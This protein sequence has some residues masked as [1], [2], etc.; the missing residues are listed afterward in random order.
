MKACG[1]VIRLAVIAFAATCATSVGSCFAK[2]AHQTQQKPATEQK[3]QPSAE[4]KAPTA[5]TPPD[6]AEEQSTAA[7]DNEADPTITAL[8]SLKWKYAPQVG[9]IG[10]E[11]TIALSSDVAF[12]GA[13]DT[14]R[15]LEI[16]GN[17]PCKQLNCYAL[18]AQSFGWFAIFSFDQSGYVKDDETIDP[19]VLLK[20]LK[21]NNVSSLDEKRQRGL[22]LLYLDGWYIP[23]HY[24][25]ISKRLEWGTKA[26][27]E[28][29][30]I[31]VNY[32]IRLLGRD[33]V[34][35]A[36]LV[37]N[38]SSLDVDLK[39]FKQALQNFTFNA[40]KTY[41]EFREGDKV[42]EYGLT[43]LIVGGA[44]AAAAK[45]GVGKGLFAAGAG[46]IKLLAVGALALL[47]GVLNFI[48]GLFSKKN[49]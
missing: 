17:L 22:P 10:N 37:S 47:V 29:G 11:A 43:A 16:N 6:Q 8:K 49:S 46:L 48:R 1:A 42:A 15:F 14:N 3:S 19:D 23:P 32:S 41:A 38:P 45:S 13:A 25:V 33:G 24:D 5:Q 31:T 12:L 7:T 35:S 44:A 20:I 39:A 36:V 34:M 21:E 40:G 27:G 28:T 30:A 4:P 9:S 18:V 2:P 26:H